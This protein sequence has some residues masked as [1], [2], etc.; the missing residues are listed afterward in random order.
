MMCMIP[1]GMI[2]FFAGGV[3]SIE[4]FPFSLIIIFFG[5]FLFM[6]FPFYVCYKKSNQEKMIIKL[7]NLIESRT[8]GIIRLET[9]Y[10]L[11]IIVKY[12]LKK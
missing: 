5:M 4:I 1:L 10:S 7:I 11:N 2:I 6:S 3:S 12:F 8:H 9:H